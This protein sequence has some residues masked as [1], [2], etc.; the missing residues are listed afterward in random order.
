M[1]V[2][3]EGETSPE[4][5]MELA[6]MIRHSVQTI[7]MMLDSLPEK[8]DPVSSNALREFSLSMVAELTTFVGQEG[9]MLLRMVKDYLPKA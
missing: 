8:A 4:M 1:G 6:L 3:D 9:S 5:T 2:P 7:N